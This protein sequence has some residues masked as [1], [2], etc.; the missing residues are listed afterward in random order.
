MPVFNILNH[1]MVPAH[2][3]LSEKE[4]EAV[5]KRLEI[6]REQLPKIKITDPAIVVLSTTSG[7]K[8]KEGMIVEITRKSKTSERF[9]AYRLIT[10]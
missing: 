2:R 1:E 7:E 6:S 9:V 8:V 3:L 10:A 5:L 4:A